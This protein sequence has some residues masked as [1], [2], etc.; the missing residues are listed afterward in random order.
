MTPEGFTM[1][2]C[3]A[4]E[5][6]GGASEEILEPLRTAVRASAFG[7]LVRTGCLARHLHCP[8]HAGNRVRRAGLRAVVQPCTRDRTPVGPALTLGPLTEVRDAEA[9]AAWL[10]EGLRL[11]RRPPA[12]LTA[13]RPSGR[14][15]Q[16]KPS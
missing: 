15:A 4:P 12:R 16:P 13:V 7:M 11:G 3:G 1:A 5:G 10:T 8:H 6:C 14:G 2:V 9:L